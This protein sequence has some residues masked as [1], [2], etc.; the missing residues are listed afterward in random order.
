M[1]VFA[2]LMNRRDAI[3]IFGIKNKLN[4]KDGQKSRGNKIYVNQCLRPASRQLLGKSNSLRKEKKLNLF[5]TMNSKI[6]IRLKRENGEVNTK[7]NY[8]ADLVDIFGAE[9]INNINKER[10]SCI[11]HSAKAC[12]CIRN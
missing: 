4:D 1:T 6:K 11:L 8:E 9:L 2:K 10:N 12:I 7:I 5:Y 3:I